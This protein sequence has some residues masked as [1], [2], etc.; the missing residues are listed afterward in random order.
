MPSENEPPPKTPD[1]TTRPPKLQALYEAA[2]RLAEAMAERQKWANTL[3][4]L[5]PTRGTPPAT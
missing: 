2:R 4:A 3:A 1:E 5:E